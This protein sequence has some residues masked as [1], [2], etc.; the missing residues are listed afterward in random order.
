MM[1]LAFVLVGVCA[2]TAL[3]QSPAPAPAATLKG[4]WSATAGRQAF[5]GYWSAKLAADSPDMASGGWTLLGP[6]GQ[7]AMQGRWSAQKT[8]KVWKG[9]WSADVPGTGVVL[10]GTWQ[11]DARTVA[12]KTF[13]DMLR[14]AGKALVTGSWRAGAAR[15]IWRLAT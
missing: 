11:A 9:T 3:A 5:A 1:S 7:I 12:G 13:E 10:S 14:H 4:S 6:G 15:G 2:S 8:A